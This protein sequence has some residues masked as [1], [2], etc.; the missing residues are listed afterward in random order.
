MILF[1]KC[2]KYL[3]EFTYSM[4]REVLCN[5]D[6]HL[7]NMHRSLH[8]SCRIAYI[9]RYSDMYQMGCSLGRSDRNTR[10]PHLEEN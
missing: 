6:T 3:K 10:Y 1:E 7:N 2:I 8:N 9:D 5:A 4:H